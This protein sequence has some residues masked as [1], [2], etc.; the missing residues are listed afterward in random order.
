MLG[1]RLKQSSPTENATNYQVLH[2]D[3]LIILL[4]H[5]MQAYAVQELIKSGGR[6]S[7]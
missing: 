4:D 6:G 7:I 2:K 1:N 3:I 5:F